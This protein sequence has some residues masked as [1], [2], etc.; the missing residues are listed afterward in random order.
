[1]SFK[2]FGGHE[3][4]YPDYPDLDSK[5]GHLMWAVITAGTLGV[6]WREA[7]LVLGTGLG[8]QETVVLPPPENM[9]QGSS[10]VWNAQLGY[11]IVRMFR[12][13]NGTMPL[14]VK[15]VIG[16]GV[17]GD[18]WGYSRTDVKI[19]NVAHGQGLIVGVVSAYLFDFRQKKPLV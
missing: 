4:G 8:L 6:D 9:S 19:N 11:L 10:F 14:W 7:L 18:I 17:A 2:P 5:R 13:F 1:M 12:R 3:Y 16:L 15:L